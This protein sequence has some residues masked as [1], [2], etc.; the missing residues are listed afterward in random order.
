MTVATDWLRVAE[1]FF[2]W[3]DENPDMELLRAESLGLMLS[4]LAPMRH[5]RVWSM[6]QEVPEVL[7]DFVRIY[8]PTIDLQLE[9]S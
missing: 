4:N 6:Q 7:Q 3:M 1:M 5:D 9:L 8:E 2:K